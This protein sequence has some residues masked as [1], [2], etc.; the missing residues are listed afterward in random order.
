MSS[1]KMTLITLHIRQPGEAVGDSTGNVLAAFTHLA[2]PDADLKPQAVANPSL[3]FRA[4]ADPSGTPPAT[5]AEFAIASGDLAIFTTDLAP[6][7]LLSPRNYSV[8]EG[9]LSAS[10]RA[11]IGVSKPTD[12]PKITITPSAP[13]SSPL[14]W[15]VFVKDGTTDQSAP[16]R[17]P[18]TP[19]PINNNDLIV[20]ISSALK[21]GTYSFLALVQ[22]L[23]PIV[24]KITIP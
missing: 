1:S 15:I 11:G 8:K 19:D 17:S 20:P 23:M 13:L 24:G 7:V 6:E 5:I 2:D 3:V 22:T 12:P 14:A 10:T 21:T 18:L 9:M 16:S 4:T